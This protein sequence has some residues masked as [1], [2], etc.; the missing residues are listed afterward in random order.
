[1]PFTLPV[2]TLSGKTSTEV[3]GLMRRVLKMSM[4]TLPDW[5]INFCTSGIITCRCGRFETGGRYETGGSSATVGCPVAGT[6]RHYC[7]G[8]EVWT[9][10]CNPIRGAGVHTCCLLWI[11][12]TVW[13]EVWT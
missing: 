13:V 7:A 2:H 8:R 4:L 5:L 6:E 3:G 11:F 12:I 1:M 10:V 9:L